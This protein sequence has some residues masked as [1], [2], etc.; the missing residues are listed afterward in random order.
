MDALHHDTLMRTVEL[1]QN[2]S[3]WVA[4]GSDP[5]WVQVVQDK[6]C[7]SRNVGYLFH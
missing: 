7:D 3:E 5:Q 2:L 4:R 1:V 6:L